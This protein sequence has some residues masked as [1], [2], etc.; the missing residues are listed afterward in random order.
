MNRGRYV[1][2][3][4]LAGVLALSV[5]V[6]QPA[7]AAAIQGAPEGWDAVDIKNPKTP[8]STTVTG[9]GAEAVWTVTGVG[10]DIW[11][12]GDQF[13]FAH[14]TLP[15]DGG[16]TARILSQ[17]GGHNDGWAKTG[18]ELR[19]SLD[20]GSLMSSWHYTN[21]NNMEGGFRTVA[22]K[23]PGNGTGSTGRNLAAGP[24]W[25]RNQRKGQEYQLLISDDGVRW[26]LVK[27]QVV[28]I[29]ASKPILAGLE[30]TQ[31]GGTVPVVATFD[32]VSVSADLIQP[33][34]A[35]PV[36]AEAFP[37]NGRVLITFGA[38]DGATGYSV[39]RR[40]ATQPAS[41]AVKLNSAA[42]KNSWFIDDKAVNGTTYVY[43]VRGIVKGASGNVETLDSPENQ[44]LP[45]API[46]N[47]GF[48]AYYWGAPLPAT[49]TLADNVLTIRASGSDIW[50]VADRGVFLAAPVAG[51]YTLTTKV[52]EI[53]L[54]EAPNT[55]NNV[56]AGPM[57]RD[58]VGPSD[59]Y[60][61]L[62]ATSGRGILWERRADFRRGGVGTATNVGEGGKGN[63]THANVTY[64]VW[65]RLVK[66]GATVTA[67]AS[68]DGTTFAQVDKAQDFTLITPVTYAGIAVSSGNGA[69]YGVA[70]FD[71]SGAGAIQITPNAP[72]AP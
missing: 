16:I 59:R 27:S 64:P 50:D 15:G 36:R 5:G 63:F 67:H 68:N 45:M 66:A 41:A 29:D 46:G 25:L 21:G 62:F 51:D 57:I 6:K 13:H 53:P 1:Q 31:H 37:G 28:P 47:A 26:R 54:A 14:T 71:A 65:L 2:F 9:T 18:V 60:A 58:G 11:G 56:K 40:E 35:G 33:S 19:E 34:A 4:V 8:G 3:A 39:Y 23:E 48:Q 44:V 52:L 17:T 30:A 49:I 32:N 70:K 43:T 42:T 12:T 69:G 7:F 10:D 20:P 24:I 72:P 55:S 22:K 61:F 38:V